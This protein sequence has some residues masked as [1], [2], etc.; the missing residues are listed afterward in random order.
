[1]ADEP[2][3]NVTLKDVPSNPT[4]AEVDDRVLYAGGEPVALTDDQLVRLKAT[5]VQLKVA[6]AAPEL[7]A[8]A[9]TPA[10]ASTG[11]TPKRG[12]T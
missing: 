7:A 12:N 2:T 3:Q 1:M 6:D 8:D 10:A 11:G 9:A 5:G 4:Q